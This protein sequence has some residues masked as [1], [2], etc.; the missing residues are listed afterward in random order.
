MIEFVRVG[1][2]IAFGLFLSI[3]ALSSAAFAQSGVTVKINGPGNQGAYVDMAP[4]GGGI[5][6]PLELETGGAGTVTVGGA[7]ADVLSGKP[8]QPGIYSVWVESGNKDAGGNYIGGKT[9]TYVDK[10]GVANVGFDLTGRPP[11]DPS[12]QTLLAIGQRAKAACNL[13]T[14]QR[15]INQLTAYIA[16]L[17]KSRDDLQNAINAYLQD[18]AASGVPE[19][20][21]TRLAG[22]LLAGGPPKEVSD[23]I[24]DIRNSLKGTPNP[25]DGLA[26]AYHSLQYMEAEQ[27]EYAG[28]IAQ[29]QPP[30]DCPKRVA[31]Y[32]DALKPINVG[33]KSAVGCDAKLRQEIVGGLGGGGGLGGLGGNRSFGFGGGGAPSRST[34]TARPSTAPNEPK[35]SPDPVRM[36]MKRY[37][38]GAYDTG[39]NFGTNFTDK[40]FWLSSDIVKAPCQGTFQTAYVRDPETG[41]KAGPTDYVLTSLYADWKLT[42]HWTYDRYVN[43][44]HVEHKQGGWQDSGRLILGTWTE[45]S[46]GKGVWDDLGWSTAVAGAK[47]MGFYFPMPYADF[48]AKPLDLVVHITNPDTDPVR[49]AGFGFETMPVMRAAGDYGRAPRALPKAPSQ[50]LPYEM[51]W[52]TQFTP[53]FRYVAPPPPPLP[54]VSLQMRF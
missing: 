34:N 17:N 44:E 54:P 29:L 24:D 48:S 42:V 19:P 45:P 53:D 14:Y 32:N 23:G 39:I 7:N 2:R 22:I 52:K 40:G 37:F 43:S 38:T 30:P 46:N 16:D 50:K 9:Y 35:I 41:Y 51:V 36:E 47:G 18:G 1:S 5:S 26:Q 27:G 8:L 28:Y 49:T 4:I 21:R 11:I 31:M 25:M 3:I 6:N 33:G 20:Q 13:V 10:N 15:V 12:G